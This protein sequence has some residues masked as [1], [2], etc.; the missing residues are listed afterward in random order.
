MFFWILK[1][2]ANTSNVTEFSFAV[3]ALPRSTSL[4]V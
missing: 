4:D 3:E 1:P 2:E